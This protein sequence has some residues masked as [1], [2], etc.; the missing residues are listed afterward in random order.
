MHLR[1]TTVMGEPKRIDDG[2]AFLRE[3]VMPT[4]QQTDGCLG[5]HAG[6]LAAADD[7]DAGGGHGGSAYRARD[8]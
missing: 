1:S 4:L 8:P 7:G 6:E 3:K 5:R 2:V